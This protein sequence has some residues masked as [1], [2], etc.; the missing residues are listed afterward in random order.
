M[1]IEF[2]G[3]HDN[4]AGICCAAGARERLR[5]TVKKNRRDNFPSALGA[6]TLEV[7]PKP[8]R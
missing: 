8:S 7:G 5:K 4:L 6:C 3:A 1:N 2:L